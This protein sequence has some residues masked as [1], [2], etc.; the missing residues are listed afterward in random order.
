[1]P[2]AVLLERVGGG[3]QDGDVAIA[4]VQALVVVDVQAAS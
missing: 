2:P 1:M 3:W 4:A